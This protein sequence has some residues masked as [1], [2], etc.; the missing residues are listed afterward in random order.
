MCYPLGEFLVGD[1][2]VQLGEIGGAPFYMS[3]AQFDYWKHTKLIIDVVPGR[4]A[5]SRSGPEGLRFLTLAPVHRGESAELRDRRPERR[6]RPDQSRRRAAVG[7][8]ACAFGALTVIVTCRRLGV[9]SR[10]S[11]V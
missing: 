6:E 9:V 11:T 7:R 3:R 10:T 2:D 1:A 8:R 5:C 4:A